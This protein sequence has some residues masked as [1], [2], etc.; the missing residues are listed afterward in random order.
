MTDCA[1]C[2]P[3]YRLGQSTL[4]FYYDQGGQKCMRN[5]TYWVFHRSWAFL[6][7]ARAVSSVY[8]GA[9]DM[10]VVVRAVQKQLRMQK[11]SL[12]DSQNLKYSYEARISCLD[13]PNHSSCRHFGIAQAEA[14]ETAA[15]LIHVYSAALRD[16]LV[17]ILACNYTSFEQTC[18]VVFVAVVVAATATCLRRSRRTPQSTSYR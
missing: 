16:S 4:G 18:S 7:L 17:K 15:L 6:T 11:V 8:G 13:M 3:E 2:Y 9:R 10:I 12:K 14:R 1:R 5:K